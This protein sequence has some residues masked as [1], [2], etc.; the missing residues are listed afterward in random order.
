MQTPAKENPTSL[1]VSP[2]RADSL[3][4]QAREW[5]T[6]DLTAA[7]VNQLERI[8]LGISSPTELELPDNASDSP[9][10]CVLCDPEGL[11]LAVLW[12]EAEKPL[13]IEGLQLPER[14][15][16][17]DLRKPPSAV[18]ACPNVW[19]IDGYETASGATWVAEQCKSRSER[20]LVQIF[21][22]ST[23]VDD[24]SH[25]RRVRK[26]LSLVKNLGET[27]ADVVLLSVDASADLETRRRAASIYGSRCIF[28]R[29]P[30]DADGF[31]A[32]PVNL[33]TPEPEQPS[34]GGFTVFF[35]GLSGSG[36]S[37]IANRVLVKLMEHGA[38][39]VTMLDGDLVRKNLSSELSFS[40]EHRNL[41]IRRIGFV[42][43]LITRSGGIAVC[44]PIAPYDAIRKEVRRNIEAEG[45]FVLIHVATPVEECE[46]RDRKGLYAKARAGIIKEFTG[47]SD[48]YEAPTDAEIVIDTLSTTPDAA[49]NNVFN[50]LIQQGWIEP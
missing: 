11:R 29:M 27:V 40:R 34:G 19:Q 33:L 24:T 50:W 31:R 43:S 47:I 3:R 30:V 2:E 49:A 25:F 15:D 45:R 26:A 7:G 18:D 28:T 14:Y 12:L 6:A 5:P 35:T 37:T 48:P 32:I 38:K 20:L 46:R 4:S 42:A 16:F 21:S 39:P 36:K 8:L 10:P 13:R 23:G 22:E 1:L 44:A 9:Q 17:Q 41:N